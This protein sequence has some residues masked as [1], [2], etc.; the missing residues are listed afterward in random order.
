[1]ISRLGKRS[2][3]ISDAEIGKRYGR[4]FWILSTLFFAAKQAGVKLLR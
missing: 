4:A 1:M 2:I 3:I